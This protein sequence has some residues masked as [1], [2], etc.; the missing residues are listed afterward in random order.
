MNMKDYYRT[1]GVADNATDA[2]EIG[3]REKPY[4]VF[5]D[6]VLKG[7][8]S[9]IELAQSS[10]IKADCKIIFM[11]GSPVSGETLKGIEDCPMMK[12]PFD[13]SQ[14]KSAIEQVWTE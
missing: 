9:G 6:M 7:A 2:L 5:L 12:K 13:E 3:Q 14:V 4:I 1:L 10:C 8:V 11:T